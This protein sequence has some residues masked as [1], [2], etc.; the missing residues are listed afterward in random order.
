M[1][2]TKFVKKKI[3]FGIGSN[4]GDR[5]DNI[6]KAIK[7]LNKKLELKNQLISF[8]FKNPPLLPI[9]SPKNW[10]K[11]FINIAFLAEIDLT[12][13]DP[14]KI[15]KIVKIIENE[16][17]RIDRA[18]WAPREIDIDI[19]MIEDLKF[20][21]KDKLTIP[22]YDINNRDFFKKTMFDIEPKWQNW[23]K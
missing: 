18:R 10:K 19:L 8:F 2:S 3:I 23:I 17:G 20:S 5:K 12:I 1:N 15:L 4:L 22:H 13:Y 9:N 14:E 21:I 11:D 16:I 7:L 6:R